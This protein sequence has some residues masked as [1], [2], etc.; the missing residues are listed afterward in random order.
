MSD[1]WDPKT[2][3]LRG[4]SEA[5][6]SAHAERTLE[7]IREGVR[8]GALDVADYR[9]AVDRHSGEDN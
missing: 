1:G 9:A 7:Q 8:E 3:D 2:A 5:A 4:P 6:D